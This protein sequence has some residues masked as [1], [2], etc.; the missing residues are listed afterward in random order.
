[1]KTSDIKLLT[2][3]SE[4]GV[5]M[6]AVLF[7]LL[8]LTVMGATA[9]YSASTDLEIAGNMRRA[10]QQQV[11]AKGASDNGISRLPALVIP[12]AMKL[13]DDTYA[14]LGHSGAAAGPSS[15]AAITGV[16]GGQSGGG[17]ARGRNVANGLNFSDLS[18]SGASGSTAAGT[19]TVGATLPLTQQSMVR[20]VGYCSPTGASG[21]P[22]T[23][24][25]EQIL[26][27]GL[28]Q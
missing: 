7:V 27:F 13:A 15:R 20:V 8:G 18:G 19:L 17:M 9:M 1:M 6:A 11:C 24:E 5:V 28:E 25:R 14:Q 21:S 2:P 16:P 4:R 23:A 10:H 3:S 12:D 22:G 26:L